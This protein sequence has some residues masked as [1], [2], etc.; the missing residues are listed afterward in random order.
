MSNGLKTLNNRSCWK[1]VVLI[2]DD[3]LMVIC[4]LGSGM[5][6]IGVVDV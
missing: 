5:R 2:A 4:S 3:L 1:S 6:R